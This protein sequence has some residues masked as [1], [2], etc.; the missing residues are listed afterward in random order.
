MGLY[1]DGPTPVYSV[2]SQLGDIATPVLPVPLLRLACTSSAVV[3]HFT[4]GI[5]LRVMA[6]G[7]RLELL[8]VPWS[9]AASV[10]AGLSPMD[11]WV[12]GET[13]RSAHFEYHLQV[14]C[15]MH[16]I[17]LQL[18]S[19]WALAAGLLQASRNCYDG[20]T[21]PSASGSEVPAGVRIYSLWVF[22]AA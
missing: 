16:S 20:S 9:F 5:Y 7:V 3:A 17:K 10:A 8:L 4:P 13:E 15:N 18:I 11:R 6:A 1:F 21:P 19:W 22:F 12:R 2:L 14:I